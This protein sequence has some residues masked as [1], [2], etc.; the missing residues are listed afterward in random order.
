MPAISGKALSRVELKSS[1]KPLRG[2]VHTPPD[3][4]ISH[5]AAIFAGIANG[6]SRIKNYLRAADTLSTLNVLRALGVQIKEGKELVIEG[7]GL[8]GLKEPGDVLDCGN[9]GTTMRLFSGLLSGN[10]FFSVLT[11]DNSLK[12][13]PMKRVILP[14]SKMGARISARDDDRYPP[15][16]IRG[17]GLKGIR[18]EMPVASA[19]VKSAL[20]LAGLYARGETRITE[21]APS[22]DHTE[23][24]LS[25]MGAHIKTNKNVISVQPAKK[26]NPFDISV[27]GDFSSAAFF[28]VAGLTV[29]GSEVL[30]KNTGLN[31]TRT[32]LLN[33]LSRMGAKIEILNRREISGEPVADLLIKSQPLNATQIGPEE[34]PLLIDEVPIIAIAAANASGITKIKGAGELRV[35]ESDRL[36]AIAQGLK[37]MGIRVEEYKDGLAIEGGEMKGNRVDSF[38]DHRIAMAFSVAAL[39]AKGKTIIEDP[40][41]VNI[42][43][44]GFYGILK[45]LSNG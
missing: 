26:L 25:S 1:V 32:G 17:G 45:K 24:M 37:R 23:I 8:H 21:R 2:V 6:K 9:S 12:S 40:D 31:H 10:D 7:N 41:A 3:K 34:I 30:I 13:R 14:L 19:Q 38:G 39:V 36:A 18:Y 11:G 35:K 33:V 42:S 5:R 29:P 4:S 22:R 27:P 20:I 16:A 44:P 15:I 43:F 28:I